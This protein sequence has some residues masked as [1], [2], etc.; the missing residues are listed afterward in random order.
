MKIKSHLTNT[1]KINNYFES[2]ADSYNTPINQEFYSDLAR[3][4]CRVIIKKDIKPKKILEIGCGC[5]FATAE[6]VKYF[7]GSDIVALDPVAPLLAGAKKLL[8]DKVKFIN[9]SL[10]TFNQEGQA[11]LVIANMSYHWFSK[12]ERLT[13]SKIM[14]PGGSLALMIPMRVAHTSAWLSRSYSG[15]YWLV[16]AFREVMSINGINKKDKSRRGLELG[17]LDKISIGPYLLEEFKVIESLEVSDFLKAIMSRGILF[18]LFGDNVNTALTWLSKN[19][20]VDGYLQLAW[21]L[22]IYLITNPSFL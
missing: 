16:K 2:V 11:D 6:I 7:P 14:K 3:R 21:P 5:G 10:A 4:L 19:L 22:A 17:E 9:Q 12:D 1:E 20:P 13:L 15:N 8:G 18:A